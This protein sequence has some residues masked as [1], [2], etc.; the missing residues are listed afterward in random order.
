MKIKGLWSYNIKMLIYFEV[1]L[2]FIKLR[3]FT[4]N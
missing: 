2:G 4:K 3:V 1:G